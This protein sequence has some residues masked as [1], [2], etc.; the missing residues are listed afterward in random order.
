MGD[1]AAHAHEVLEKERLCQLASHSAA[2]AAAVAGALGALRGQP[3]LEQL[4]GERTPAPADVSQVAFPSC[5]G[6]SK[7]QAL[8]GRL[9]GLEVVLEMGHAAW[10]PSGQA[11]TPQARR[12]HEVDLRQVQALELLSGQ[13]HT[14]RPPAWAMPYLA[15]AWQQPAGFLCSC[16]RKPAEF[17]K[18]V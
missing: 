6:D 12:R 3:R 2:A 8:K 9:R 1:L 14:W 13:T 5:L 10:I 4:L 18:V 15:A 11:L 16:L 7:L 17:V